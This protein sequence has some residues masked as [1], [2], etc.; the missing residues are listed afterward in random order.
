MSEVICELPDGYEPSENEE[1]MCKEHLEFFRRMLLKWKSELESSADVIT[2]LQEE[3]NPGTDFGDRAY[4]EA[5]MTCELR[6]KNREMKALQKVLDALGRIENGT[7]GYCIVT[8]EP[9]GLKRLI[10]RPIATLSIEAQEKHERDE[11][12]GNI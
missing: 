7:Y 3:T 12:T 6:T 11:R 4:V 2:Y 1:Y 10:A 5:D 9:I 8:G